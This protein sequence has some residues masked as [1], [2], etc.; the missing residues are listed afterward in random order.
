MKGQH[1]GVAM[2][3]T[4]TKKTKT[5][6]N[7]SYWTALSLVPL[8]CAVW[9]ARGEDP[10]DPSNSLEALD[11]LKE[12]HQTVSAYK[13]EEIKQSK[14]SGEVKL[15]DFLA[16]AVPKKMGGELLFPNMPTELE[17]W[18]KKSKE[19]KKT[20]GELA[21]RPRQTLLVLLEAALRS[22]PITERD[23]NTAQLLAEKVE[24]LGAKISR[25][26]IYS[27]LQDIPAAIEKRGK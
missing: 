2:S 6:A 10:N 5:T 13:A 15:T 8:D 12:W 14:V 27:Y 16:W 3:E 4:P 19:Y 7:Y 1:E 20:A 21:T 25:R 22:N 11:R 26:T 18:L 17:N 9:L 24:L 23:S